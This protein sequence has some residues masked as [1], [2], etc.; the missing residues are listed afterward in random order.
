[1]VVVVVVCVVWV[2]SGCGLGVTGGGSRPVAAQGPGCVPRV[3]V[4]CSCV[5]H[6]R[7]YPL[8]LCPSRR[9][10][11]RLVLGQGS[12]PRRGLHQ[13]HARVKRAAP[14][15]CFVQS[16]IPAR[17][18]VLEPI[19]GSTDIESSNTGTIGFDAV[20]CATRSHPL[21][22]ASLSAPASVHPRGS[23]ADDTQ[24]SWDAAMAPSR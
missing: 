8:S 15:R 22:C 7:E 9:L 14:S 23:L 19:W 16:V 11:H 1:M 21:A 17:P 5:S 2:W 13:S 6:S 4:V 12:V 10:L 18:E 20:H 3:C 24:L